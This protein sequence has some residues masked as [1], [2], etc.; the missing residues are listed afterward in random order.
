MKHPKHPSIRVAGC[1]LAGAALGLVASS[2]LTPGSPTE[3]PVPGYFGIYAV[4]GDDLLSLHRGKSS[5]GA[6]VGF[7]EFEAFSWA[8]GKSKTVKAPLF[9]PGVTFLVFDQSSGAVSQALEL[10]RL[11]HVRTYTENPDTI[12][13]GQANTFPINTLASARVPSLEVTLLARPV[14]DQPQMVQ[15]VP[16]VELAPGSYVLYTETL[17][18][19]ATKVWWLPFVVGSPGA[20]RE[21]TCIDVQFPWGGRAGV[22]EMNEYLMRHGPVELLE[23]VKEHYS[24]C[25]DVESPTAIQQAPLETGFAETPEE[26]TPAAVRASQRTLAVS[27]NGQEY[28]IV[29]CG[30]NA[31][32][33]V[34]LGATGNPVEDRETLSALAAA[35]WIHESVVLNEY[36]RGS[37]RRVQSVVES[38]RDLAA[39]EEAQDLLARLLV[40]ALEISVSGGAALAATVPDVA[41]GA[42]R[43]KLVANPRGFFVR[44]A[45]RGL[46]AAA[47]GYGQM[48][49]MCEEL[50]DSTIA[51]EELAKIRDLYEMAL[52]LDLP[53]SALDA[54]LRSSDALDLGKQGA[55]SIGEQLGNLLPMS[56]PVTMGDLLFLEDK[57]V[58]VVKTDSALRRYHENYRLA[59]RTPDVHAFQVDRLVANAS[60]DCPTVPTDAPQEAQTLS[61]PPPPPGAPQSSSVAG[62]YRRPGVTGDILVLRI[63]GTF[64][65]RFEGHHDTGTY[66]VSDDR[67]DFKINRRGVVL[68]LA[69]SIEGSRI[70]TSQGFEWV[71]TE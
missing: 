16:A 34:Y 40:T 62:T 67:V 4:E 21:S 30:D 70:V 17:P 12:W 38:S 60:S 18:G 58:D 19:D 69:A 1:A 39:Y 10:Y 71:K 61:L 59:R 15:V 35:S 43:D 22:W 29:S 2:L 5:T 65:A 49:A 28:S 54:A 46:E 37:H 44:W 42:V 8:H 68:P 63:D 27:L 14:P 48:E 57:M 6:Q 66:Q 47:E 24:T 3:K 9:S 36:V 32:A 33:Q 7:L 23:I 53:S 64:E 55:V 26:S 25:S 50:G 13:G 56:G 11:P 51:A 52:Q 41:W 20:S 45:W 31:P